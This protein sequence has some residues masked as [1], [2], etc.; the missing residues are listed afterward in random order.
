MIGGAEKAILDR[1]L[2]VPITKFERW[3]LVSGHSD[4]ECQKSA[5]YEEYCSFVVSSSDRFFERF[6]AQLFFVRFKHLESKIVNDVWVSYC[7]SIVPIG[8]WIS[9]ND[10]GMRQSHFDMPLVQDG[11][12]WQ[13]E[14]SRFIQIQK[15]RVVL[16]FTRNW[17]VL[18]TAMCC[19]LALCYAV[20]ISKQSMVSIFE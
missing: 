13:Q 17:N 2:Q 12:Q 19:L 6:L 5:F 1:C 9:H 11:L 18:L 10:V 14:K 3:L 4:E 15:R 7:L 20:W 16:F 8:F